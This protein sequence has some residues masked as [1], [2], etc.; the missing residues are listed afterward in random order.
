MD[1]EPRPHRHPRPSDCH[2]PSFSSSLLDAIYRSIDQTDHDPPPPSLHR[3]KDSLTLYDQV[4]PKDVVDIKGVG[5]SRRSCA[6]EKGSATGMTSERYLVVRRESSAGRSYVP[7]NSSGSSSDSSG[8]LSSESE[9]AGS[10]SSS[11]C[12]S[13]KRPKPIRTSISVEGAPTT[14]F[15]SFLQARSGEESRASVKVPQREGSN[16]SKGRSTVKSYGDSKK[17]IRQPISPGGKLASF[18]NSIFNTKKARIAVQTIPEPSDNSTCSSASSF[19]RSCLSVK[20]PSST[21]SSSS[22][23]KSAEK[24]SVRFCPVSVILDE[25]CHPCGHKSLVE[26]AG[27]RTDL[28]RRT[29]AA[30]ASAVR[31][32][33]VVME[34]NRRVAEA[35]REMLRNYQ[36]RKES[37]DNGDED[38]DDD[39]AASC[40]SSDLFELDNLDRYREELPVYGTTSVGANLAIANGLMV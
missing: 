24:R 27:S 30:A 14:E 25:D 31:E 10:K 39:D 29:T 28:A 15:R 17:V 9:F 2:H 13:T 4:F 35:A 12:Y 6:V 3:P 18:L 19:S 37:Y 5:S 33:D 26:A 20:T 16:V 7:G 1:Y 22:R 23:R 32:F 11:S 36:K 21:A 8:F 34:E 40:T 38:E